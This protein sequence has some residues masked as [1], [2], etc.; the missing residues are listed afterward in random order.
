[1]CLAFD[2][3]SLFHLDSNGT[4][5][6]SG[7]RDCI[8]DIIINV[9]KSFFSN[10]NLNVHG[11]IFIIFSVVLNLFLRPYR[12]SP[13][14]FP[15]GVKAIAYIVCRREKRTRIPWNVSS[16][17]KLTRELFNPVPCNYWIQYK[18]EEGLRVFLCVFILKRSLVIVE[19]GKRK[20]ECWPRENV[21][22]VDYTKMSTR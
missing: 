9:Y 4:L 20:A 17:S 21:F 6:T 5:Q 18:L 19:S 22:R 11:V 2:G 12:Y 13:S 8:G 14:I 15:K 3:C 1:M 10:Q 16:I 7:I